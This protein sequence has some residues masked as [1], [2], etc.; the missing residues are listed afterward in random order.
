MILVGSNFIDYHPTST[1]FA[2]SE[3][4]PGDV[5][6][7][8]F[9]SGALVSASPGTPSPLVELCRVSTPN[10][11]VA[12]AVVDTEIPSVSWEFGQTVGNVWSVVFRAD[13][14][15]ELAI[16]DVQ[17]GTVATVSAMTYPALTLDGAEDSYV[18][19]AAYR[20]ASGSDP[21]GFATDPNGQT[22]IRLCNATPFYLTT[23]SAAPLIAWPAATIETGGAEGAN[24]HRYGMAIEIIESAV[25]QPAQPATRKLIGL[26]A[27]GF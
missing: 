2:L 9:S 26:A 22:R 11:C 13:P 6:I 16:G 12:A 25:A 18:F 24:Q 27:S 1:P 23:R 5:V 4:A 17:I 3:H 8:G 7:C 14:G 15:K 20:R 21:L 19:T 10:S